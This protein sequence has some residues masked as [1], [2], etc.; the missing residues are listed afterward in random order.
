MTYIEDKTEAE[1]VDNI[2]S[3]VIGTTSGLKAQFAQAELTR[4]LIVSIRDLDRTT[5]K[6]SRIIVL[7][8]VVLGILAGIQIWITLK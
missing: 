8:T 5:S 3:V 2:G 1:L 6:Y 4:R 7:L